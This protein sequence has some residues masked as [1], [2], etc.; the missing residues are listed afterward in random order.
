LP[1]IEVTIYNKDGKGKKRKPL[2]LFILGW[3]NHSPDE[4]LKDLLEKEKGYG[5]HVICIP[6]RI[7]QSFKH[8][9]VKPTQD[10]LDSMPQKPVAIFSHSAGGLIARYLSAGKKA[11]F[12][13]F[14]PLWAFYGEKLR[15]SMLRFL[16]WVRFVN[17]DL[18]RV[19]FTAE[20]L[21]DWKDFK[22]AFKKLPKWVSFKWVFEM[23]NA[24]KNMPPVKNK[25]TVFYSLSE[26]VIGLEG[27]GDEQRK[28]EHIK[29]VRHGGMHE[30]FHSK[31]RKNIF[32]QA[33]K[34][35]RKR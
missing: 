10:Y 34:L 35:V 27:I 12:I 19:Y 1:G 15:G 26:G 21:G 2:I 29:L 14:S 25:T 28:D 13:Y 18:I 3:A 20:D 5:F 4:C 24:Q 6:T 22:A 8:D 32:K 33:M 11:R 9:Y 23:V 30:F 31:E 16:R 7:K 17:L